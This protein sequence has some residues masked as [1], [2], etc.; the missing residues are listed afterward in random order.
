MCVCVFSVFVNGFV[1]RAHVPRAA[2]MHCC[3]TNFQHY[4][5][6][7]ML[8]DDGDGDDDDDGGGDVCHYHSEMCLRQQLTVLL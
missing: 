7:R 4:T 2:T 6:L 5:Q 3:M 8:T 1:N